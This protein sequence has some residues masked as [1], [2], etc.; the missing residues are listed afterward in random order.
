MSKVFI[1]LSLCLA[2]PFV[3]GAQAS[4]DSM[5]SK[6][7]TLAEAGK[8]DEAIPI[9]TELRRLYPDDNDYTLLLGRL[10]SWKSE[11]QAASGY[12]RPLADDE[13][14]SDEALEALINVYLWSGKNDSAMYYARI[15]MERFPRSASFTLTKA[16]LLAL[17]GHDKESLQLLESL[18]SLR[19]NARY[20]ATR[21]SLLKRS[22][23]M[24][25]LSYLNTS[26]SNPGADPWHLASA[27]YKRN[28][29]AM[30]LIARLNYGHLFN[31]DA[32][33]FEA[34]AYPKIT[35]NTY[36]Y[37]N[38][39]LAD[40]KAIFPNVK[41]ALE[42]YTAWKRWTA[43]VGG[44]WLNFKPEGV[45][46]FSGHLGY[47]LSQWHIQYRPFLTQTSD[48]WSLSHG[49]SVKRINEL[50]ESFV[51]FDFQYGVIPFVFFATND[52]NRVN[53]VRLGI[54]YRCRI[55]DRIFLHPAFMYEREEYYPE[56]FRNRFNTQL[57]VGFRF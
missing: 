19:G 42:L 33:Q 54:Q 43:S 1:W 28:F 40:G 45:Y 57:G 53:A 48:K 32:L 34:E 21:T 24:V 7:K 38:I 41:A 55:G 23:N 27:E 13:K 3:S 29:T 52:V 50:K 17:Q 10:Y 25:S 5:L 2:L 47:Q 14:G 35:K 4:A 6:A 49:V 26:F 51:Q 11:Y 22:K 56:L 31:N 37:A 8:Y 18:D 44:R 20:E 39:S 30:P 15:G 46:I 9:V 12:L 16:Q 36:L